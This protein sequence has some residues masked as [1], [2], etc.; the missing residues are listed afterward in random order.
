MSPVAW[1]VLM[2]VAEELLLCRSSAE[3]V[4]HLLLTVGKRLLREGRAVGF[5]WWP[6][7]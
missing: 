7:E 5:Q 3:H 4:A 6:Q 1:F 2:V